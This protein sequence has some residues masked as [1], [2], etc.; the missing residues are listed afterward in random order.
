MAIRCEIL[1]SVLQLSL[2]ELDADWRLVEAAADAT[3]DIDHWCSGPDWQIPVACAFAPTA[4]RV[5][6][7]SEE[8]D[9]FALLAR[10]H[11]ER[12][13]PLF[14]GLEPLWGFGAPIL[15]SNPCAMAAAAAEAL[16]RRDD[17][18]A[19]VLPGMP[20]TDERSGSS[21]GRHSTMTMDVAVTLSSLGDVRFGQG[22]TRQIADLS[23]G[24]EGWLERRSSKFRRNLRRTA[25]TA[26]GAGLT[27]DDVAGQPGLFER[28][29]A[30]ERRSWKG[31]EGS[32]MAGAEM[33]TMYRLMIDRLRDRGRLLAHVARL[34]G[35]DVG[36]IVGGVRAGRYRGLQLS[37]TDDARR[38]SVGNL[39]QR[40]QLRQLDRARL[41]DVYDLGMDFGYKRRW[42]DRA[43]TSLVIAVD[44]R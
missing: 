44:R 37:Y 20:R 28:L 19:L 22:I 30:I 26:A 4:E 40:H 43:E 32:G 8:G 29:M 7:R 34:D 12:R 39:L 38:L 24:Y 14:G 16:A 6:L 42:A 17:W 18:R 5:L 3:A 1:G 13:T 11:D 10:Y 27:I 2:D 31:R 35:R 23:D 21:D 33:S 36:Y 9:G 25:A 41:A 15:G